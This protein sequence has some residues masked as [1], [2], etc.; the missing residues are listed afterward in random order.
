MQVM[1]GPMH[2]YIVCLHAMHGLCHCLH[3]LRGVADVLSMTE[4][5]VC[6]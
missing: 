3:E 6:A 4:D 5:S 1:H 2:V